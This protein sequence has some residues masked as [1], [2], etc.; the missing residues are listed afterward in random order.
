MVL[1]D[2]VAKCVCMYSVVPNLLPKGFSPPWFD[3][4]SMQIWMQ[5][6]TLAKC[7]SAIGVDWR[8]APIF[9]VKCTQP[10]IIDHSIQFGQLAASTLQ[11]RGSNLDALSYISHIRQFIMH[12]AVHIPRSTSGLHCTTLA[13]RSSTP[14]YSLKHI[15]VQCKCTPILLVCGPYVWIYREYGVAFMR[16]IGCT[17]VYANS[18]V[19]I[20]DYVKHTLIALHLC[21]PCGESA[22]A[23]NWWWMFAAIAFTLQFLTKREPPKC[24]WFSVM[25]NALF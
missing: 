24:V 23:V 6:A 1:N 7:T 18:T 17:L 5:Y 13:W 16:Y 12:H 11:I 2:K 25:I 19:N 10:I 9:G 4:G 8:R 20:P 15:S 22:L 21:V 3:N 14:P